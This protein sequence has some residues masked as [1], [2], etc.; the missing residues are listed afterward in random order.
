[1]MVALSWSW[2]QPCSG[3]E[4][5]TRERFIP[6]CFRCERSGSDS[7]AGGQRVG[8]VPVMEAVGCFDFPLGQLVLLHCHGL[9]HPVGWITPRS[10]WLAVKR[11]A[12]E[13]EKPCQSHSR[14]HAGWGWSG[15]YRLGLG[16][17]VQLW[18]HR[19]RLRISFCF[20]VTTGQ[21]QNPKARLKVKVFFRY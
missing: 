18:V 13:E 17:S 11:F 16:A 5:G 6:F 15:S 12:S 9:V 8:R 2:L 3:E 14:G 1:M 21:G 20:S 19:V 7:A 4:R 10:H